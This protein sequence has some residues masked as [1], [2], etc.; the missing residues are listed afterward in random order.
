M[1]RAVHISVVGIV[2]LAVAGTGGVAALAGHGAPAAPAENVERSVES[3]DVPTVRSA[4]A[5]LHAVADELKPVVVLAAYSRHDD[6]GPLEHEVRR[7]LYAAVRGSPGLPVAKTAREIDSPV[8]T[9]RYHVRVLE[10]EGL[11]E[12]MKLR[13]HNRL[14]PDGFG[15]DAELAAVLEDDAAR[16]VL[17]AIDRREPVTVTTLSGD[18]DRSPSTVCHH[19]ERLVDA[20]LVESQRDGKRVLLSLTARTSELLAGRGLPGSEPS[21]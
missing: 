15:G 14:Y 3:R 4:D 12:A 7:D 19:K 17:T 8:S 1:S 9:V 10:R 2:A 6:S 21:R 16:A 18:L 11:V 5:T 13:G 20:G